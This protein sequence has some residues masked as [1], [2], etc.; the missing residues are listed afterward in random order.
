MN[1]SRNEGKSESNEEQ[2]KNAYSSLNIKWNS[3][4][5]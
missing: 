3:K 1:G 5:L 2:I 4:I